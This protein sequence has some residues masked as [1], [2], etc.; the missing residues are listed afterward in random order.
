ME[1]EKKKKIT[2]EEERGDDEEQGK[3]YPYT[4][5]HFLGE[6]ESVKQRTKK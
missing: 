4:R 5:V 3:T 6:R 1:A 2:K